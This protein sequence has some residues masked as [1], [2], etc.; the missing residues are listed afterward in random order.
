M[1]KA[2]LVVDGADFLVGIFE[3]QA[4]GIFDA[5]VIDKLVE[6]IALAVDGCRYDI[7][8]DTQLGCDILYLQVAVQIEFLLVHQ[9]ADTFHKC[10]LL[11][12]VVL[13]FDDSCRGGFLSTTVDEPTSQTDS[14]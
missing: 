14:E 12:V 3:H 4:F 13:F 7:R 10:N 6:R 2:Y 11:L 1:A 5:I 9:L 8:M